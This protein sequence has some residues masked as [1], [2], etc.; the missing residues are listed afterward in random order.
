M[1]LQAVPMATYN[2]IAVKDKI[3]DSTIIR[4]K[5]KVGCDTVAK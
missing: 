3:K 4:L 5:K 1:T 2:C